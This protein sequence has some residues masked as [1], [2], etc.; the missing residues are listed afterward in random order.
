[1]TGAE[2][3]LVK[4]NLHLNLRRFNPLIL[5]DHGMD[6][7]A[8]LAFCQ[9]N[10]DLQ[11]ERTAQNQIIVMAPTSSET[12]RLNAA[13][14]GELYIWNRK[15]RLGVVFDSS[16]GFQLPTGAERAPDASWIQKGRWAALL[17]AQKQG[18]APIVPDFVLELRSLGQN[19]SDLK[20]KMQ[21]YMNCGARL[22]WLVDPANRC[23]WVYS[24]NEAIQKI[25][26]NTPLSGEEVLPGFQLAMSE[27]LE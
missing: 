21:E 4:T 17:P 11:I 13:I 18:F 22:G 10:P 8:F 3:V 1:M 16:T 23:T 2:S 6:S 26:F 14:S 24:T 19:L 5:T 7:D 25:S 9:E 27:V 15:H 12:G 20:S